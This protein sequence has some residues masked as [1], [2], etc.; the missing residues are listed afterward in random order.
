MPY[1]VALVDDH[2]HMLAQLAI[3]LKQVGEIEIVFTAR[4]G[5]DYLAQ[6]KMLEVESH[7]QVVIMDVEMP[8]MNG[9]DAV[10]NGCDL[11]PGTQYIMFTI[12]D[13]DNK[14]FDAI[15]AGADGFLL[16]D[17]P[18]EVI[19][20]AIKE[21]VEKSGAPM[22]PIIALKTLKLLARKPQAKEEE[23]PAE[24]ILSDREIEILK[25]M[26]AGLKYKQIAEKVFLS[27]F[28]VRNHITNIYQKLHI[29]SKAQAVKIAVSNRWF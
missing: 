18:T 5:A 1:K 3:G 21:V 17:E 19:V 13:D 2:P 14:L 10:K 16:K 28:T 25:A 11:Y 6:M 20:D 24:A 12:S 15:R 27:P 7:P 8:L 9:I 23:L 4:N 29:S 26:V 22:S